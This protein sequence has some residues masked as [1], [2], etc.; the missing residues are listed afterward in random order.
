MQLVRQ[1]DE[2]VPGRAPLVGGASRL[3]FPREDALA[4]EHRELH[5]GA[6]PVRRDALPR[7][8]PED[9]QAYIGAVVHDRGRR[10]IEAVRDCLACRG[11]WIEALHRCTATSPS[12]ATIAP[13]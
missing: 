5:R 12:A 11:E 4:L 6:A 10:T 9:D 8:E 1:V 3:G 7:R 2:D 13:I